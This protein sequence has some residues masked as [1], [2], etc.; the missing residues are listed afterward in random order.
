LV[1]AISELASFFYISRTDLAVL[2]AVNG[3]VFDIVLAVP[4]RLF[5]GQAIE[6]L[7]VCALSWFCA[8]DVSHCSIQSISMVIVE[9]I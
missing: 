4:E 9:D 3:V 6:N 2:N 5:S 1:K 7:G 8:Q